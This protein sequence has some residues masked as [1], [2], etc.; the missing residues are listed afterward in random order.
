MC[1]SLL[2]IF[3]VIYRLGS[4]LRASWRSGSTV[5]FANVIYEGVIHVAL[6]A[7][8]KVAG[9]ILIR[10]AITKG[11]SGGPKSQGKYYKRKVK[12]IKMAKPSEY[13][14]NATGNFCNDFILKP[15]KQNQPL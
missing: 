1:K 9:P 3:Q 12:T 14:Q 4:F 8:Y 2:N 7:A 6:C 15:K 11:C 13:S 5:A 10:K